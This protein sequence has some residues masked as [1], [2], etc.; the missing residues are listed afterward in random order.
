MLIQVDP[1]LM[2]PETAEEMVKSES[3]FLGEEVRKGMRASLKTGSLLTGALFVD[4]DY[5]PDAMPAELGHADGHTVI[6]TVSSGLAQLEAKLTAILDKVQ[7]LPLEEAMQDIAEAAREAKGTISEARDTL[8]K[9]EEMAD[10][11]RDVLEDPGLSE[12]PA[13]LRTTLAELQVSVRSV[14]PDG[15]VQGDLRRTL[16]ELRAALRSFKTLSDTIEDKPNSLLFG[17]EDSG[18]PIPRAP[19]VKP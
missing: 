4:L 14:G 10:A 13:D 12:L 5:Y 3:A 18:N 17:R 11:A 2:R 19:R 9:I 1:S 8:T 15:A 7:A 16:D 6:P